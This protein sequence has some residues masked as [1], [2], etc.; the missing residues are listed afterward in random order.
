[1]RVC[2]C[3]FVCAR[4]RRLARC[5]GLLSS[6]G[7][8]RATGS[9][10]PPDVKHLQAPAL[11]SS[12]SLSERERE[13]PLRRLFLNTLIAACPKA[14]AEE[15]GRWGWWGVEVVHLTRGY[16]ASLL[17]LPGCHGHHRY[18]L[19]SQTRKTDPAFREGGSTRRLRV[20]HPAP[21]SRLERNFC[22]RG[23]VPQLTRQTAAGINPTVGRRVLSRGQTLVPSPGRISLCFVLVSAPLHLLML[24]FFFPAPPPSPLRRSLP[25]ARLFATDRLNLA[26]KGLRGQRGQH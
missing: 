8:S 23:C 20:V 7:R 18:G 14:A 22:A 21:S 19:P 6:Q 4:C 25:P 9:G 26:A 17:S 13:K 5:L 12:V 24:D 2:V 16:A 3:V 15:G 1:M 11:G 10:A